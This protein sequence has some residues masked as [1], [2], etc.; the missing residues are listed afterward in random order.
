MPRAIMDIS[1]HAFSL[2]F[3]R[4]SP[5]LQRM[6]P[7]LCCARIVGTEV[8]YPLGAIKPVH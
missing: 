7:L 2:V 4:A 6:K 8:A 1:A 3:H 5:D